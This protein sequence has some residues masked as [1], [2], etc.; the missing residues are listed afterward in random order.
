MPA[1]H[2]SSLWRVMRCSASYVVRFGDDTGADSDVSNF[3]T[4]F[5]RAMELLTLGK[6]VNHPKL[7]ADFGL[8]SEESRELR[9]LTFVPQ[10]DREDWSDDVEVSFVLGDEEGVPVLLTREDD[11]RALLAGRIEIGRAHV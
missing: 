8:S 5:H 11:P 6:A 9:S 7:A 3:G 2:C 1:V 10:F 4:A